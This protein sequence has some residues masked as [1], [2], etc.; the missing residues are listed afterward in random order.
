MELIDRI[1]MGAFVLVFALIGII[2]L[3]G[4]IYGLVIS[5]I[6]PLSIYRKNRSYKKRLRQNREFETTIILNYYRNNLRNSCLSLILILGLFLPLYNTSRYV[7]EHV[8]Y[9]IRE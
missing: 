9:K 7:T 6:T 5:L 4:L 8:E 2:L 1:I 3:I